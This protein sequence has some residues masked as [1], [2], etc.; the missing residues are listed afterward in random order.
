[1]ADKI[2]VDRIDEMLRVIFRELKAMDGQ[3][4]PK[5][6]LAAV[7]PKLHLTAY[8]MEQTRTGAVRWNT[9][10]RFYTT[11]CV[12]AGYIRKTGG[13]WILTPGGEKALKL[14]PG[15]LIR[16]AQREYRAW[17]KARD[18]GV[19]V[20]DPEAEE[21]VVERQA[22]YEESNEKAREEVEEHINKMG[23]YDFQKLVAELLRGM[24]YFVPYVAA[25]GPDGGIDIVAYKDPLGTT[26][27]RIKVQVKHRDQK[28][29]VKEVR[30]MEALLRKDGDIGLI[31]SSG[32]IT[33]EGEREI[34][35]S[36][37]HIE[38]MDLDRLIS[39]W[40]E[41]YEKISEAGKTL[42]PLVKVYFLAPP[43]E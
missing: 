15:E 29:N 35:S 39:L 13:H 3:A 40:Q 36:T 30:E 16:S 42:L 27:P 8:E 10:V 21:D 26:S 38:A 34:R 11:D 7:A 12:K 24:G 19:D 37:K 22:I 28:V 17:K 1:M 18:A 31:V 25:P 32:G 5:D 4:K 20:V 41:H 43:E 6:L 14:P 23:A 9:H 2:S 33:S